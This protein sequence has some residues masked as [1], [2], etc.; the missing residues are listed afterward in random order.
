MA[1]TG[2][3]WFPT[4]ESA[5]RLLHPPRFDT[6][7]ALPSS[8]HSRSSWT[9]KPRLSSAQSVEA[10]PSRMPT[11]SPRPA[12]CMR[13]VLVN[14][15]RAVASRTCLV[16][17]DDLAFATFLQRVAE[18]VGLHV[19]VLTDP[20]QLEE[21]LSVA[22]PDVITLDMDMP[23][24]HGLDVLRVLSARQLAGRVIIISGTPPGYL[25]DRR[26]YVEGC[27]ITAVL[28]KPARKFEIEAALSDAL[29]GGAR[30]AR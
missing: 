29:R 10:W 17:D 26:P 13:C 19:Q 8:G 4:M 16:I 11:P 5:R 1:R 18:G 6:A 24:R 21:S 30:A 2:S 7:W 15:E 14:I 20:T 28:T 9:P 23:G 22:D 12:S 25:G 27:Q 3:W